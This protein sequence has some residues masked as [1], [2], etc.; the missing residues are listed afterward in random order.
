MRQP[1]EPPKEEVKEEAK[2][3]KPEG[4]EDE[5]LEKENKE[6]QVTLPKYGYVNIKVIY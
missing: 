5:D 4:E 3:P 6:A 2:E 1:E